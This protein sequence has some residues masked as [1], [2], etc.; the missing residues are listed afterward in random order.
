M[1]K[2]IFLVDADE[3]LADLYTPIVAAISECLGRDL[4]S[5]E[6]RGWDFFEMFG[7]EVLQKIEAL[8]GTK[9]F[10]ASLKP[11]PGAQEAIETLRTLTD[12]YVM[13]SPFFRNLDLDNPKWDSTHY[14]ATERTAWLKK[15]FGFKA[16]QVGHIPCKY[17]VQGDFFLDDRPENV[18]LWHERFPNRTAM[19]WDLQRTRHLE[20]LDKFRVFDWKHVVNIVTAKG[21]ENETVH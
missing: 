5:S 16:S 12:V 10:C 20:N 19:L 9:G 4:T 14:W 1:S 11:L 2:P 13:T 21:Q 15:H 7:E 8:M 3:V 18:T 17:L 6:I